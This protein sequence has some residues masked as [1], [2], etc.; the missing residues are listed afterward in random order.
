MEL[1]PTT[2]DKSDG[3]GKQLKTQ[4]ANTMAGANSTAFLPQ[5]CLQPLQWGPGA[6]GA[7]VELLTISRWGPRSHMSPDRGTIFAPKQKIKA[8]FLIILLFQENF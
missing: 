6:C 2:S 3:E 5:I 1:T 4:E 8:W 7:T